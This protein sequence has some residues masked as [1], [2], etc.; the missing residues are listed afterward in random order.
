M[1]GSVPWKRVTAEFVA[2]FLGVSLSLA[3]DDWRQHRTDRAT[4][5]QVLVELAAD[6]L[7]DA[8]QLEEARHGAQR[9]DVSAMWLWRRAARPADAI[10]DSASVH[11]RQLAFT[12]TYSPVAI[13][14][15]GLK[16]SGQMRLIRNDSLRRRIA[17]YYEVYQPDISRFDSRVASA[18]DELMAVFRRH[19]TITW[20]DTAASFWPLGDELLFLTSW[21]DLAA[22]PDFRAVTGGLGAWAASWA[23]RLEDVLLA[24]GEL[25]TAIDTYLER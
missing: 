15:V 5:R 16:D 25:R 4:E 17:E 2:I 21:Q 20:P 7:A 24:N 23:A 11:I 18:Y 13:A 14:Y 9:Q 22:D 6:L 19:A 10:A 1:T 12:T 8:A 3:G